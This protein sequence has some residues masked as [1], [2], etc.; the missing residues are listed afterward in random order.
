MAP[1]RPASCSAIGA[2]N[3]LEHGASSAALQEPQAR[4]AAAGAAPGG[5][6]AADGAVEMEVSRC[7]A[8]AGRR[9]ARRSPPKFITAVAA[10][11]LLAA[12]CWAC[13]DWVSAAEIARLRPAPSCRPPPPL[14][15]LPAHRRSLAGLPPCC[16]HG[17]ASTGRPAAG[18]RRARAAHQAARSQG[19]ARHRCA[20]RRRAA[21]AHTAGPAA[22]GRARHGGRPAHRRAGGQPCGS[23]G[24]VQR[25]P[26]QPLW[27][28]RHRH[29]GA[30][31]ARAGELRAGAGSC[32]CCCCDL[33]CLRCVFVG[34]A[35]VSRGELCPASTAAGLIHLPTRCAGRFRAKHS[36]C[37][38]PSTSCSCTSLAPTSQDDF[39]EG[40]A[41]AGKEAPPGEAPGFSPGGVLLG[42]T[43][44]AL[45]P[46]PLYRCAA[47]CLGCRR[48]GLVA[49]RIARCFV[50]FG[51]QPASPSV[52]CPLSCLHHRGRRLPC[53]HASHHHVRAGPRRCPRARPRC[54]WPPTA[55]W[56][57]RRWRASGGCWS[58][59]T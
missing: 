10:P 22:A 59:C 20:R 4:Q 45:G 34:A 54:R 28:P 15:P 56:D 52:P 47:G 49:R 29:T 3:G 21:H 35:H 31:A 39:D 23:D 50:S 17:A 42:G 14:L 7:N 41:P 46:A 6:A 13:L 43:S 11:P 9:P 38:R 32:C 2:Y 1:R 55:R 16:R 25:G 24:A 33:C 5:R 27:Q 8:P 57:R 37:Q 51:A 18:E 26:A 58:A 53:P 48:C 44:P 30:A 19:R 36:P 12:R 40:T